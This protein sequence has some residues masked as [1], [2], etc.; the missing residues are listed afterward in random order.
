MQTR[1]ATCFDL[2][3]VGTMG[4][5]YKEETSNHGLFPYDMD[6]AFKQGMEATID[7]NQEII[8][9]S[10]DGKD[11]GFIWVVVSRFVWSSAI[12]ATDQLLFVLP[13]HRGSRAG[14]KLINA[15]KEWA[16]S[17][18]AV[19]ANLSV[20]SGIHQER[21]AALYEKLGFESLG[22]THRINL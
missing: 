17:K 16:L 6:Y 7:P 21:T 19:A 10:K 3:S 8:I 20:A 12:V 18:G 1:Y 22:Y 5:A 9:L 2:L 14:I 15:Y 13:E 4:K 11:I